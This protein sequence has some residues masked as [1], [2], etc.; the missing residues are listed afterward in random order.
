LGINQILTR[1]SPK[2]KF[3][4]KREGSGL[5]QTGFRQ[6]K[7]GF[8]CGYPKFLFQKQ[9]FYGVSAWKKG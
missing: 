7:E 2:K 4:D 3:A 6:W 9:R 1:G 8:R 5:L